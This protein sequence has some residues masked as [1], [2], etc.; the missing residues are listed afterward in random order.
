LGVEDHRWLDYHDG[1]CTEVPPDEAIAKVAALIEEIGPDSVLTFGPEGM[2]GHPDHIA[3]SAWTTAAFKRSARPGARL[4]YAGQTPE[5]AER[6]VARMNE[7]TEVFAPG[8]PPVTSRDD[9]GI[10]FQLDVD[11][12]MLKFEAIN[13]QPSQFEPFLNA[14]DKDFFLEAQSEEVYSL[15]ASS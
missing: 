8:T 2:T 7:F 1:S 5:W 13:K 11:L 3:V 6:W 10:F 9:L 4:Y 15:A 12:T 14:F